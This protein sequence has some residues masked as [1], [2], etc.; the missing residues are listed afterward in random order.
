MKKTYDIYVTYPEELLTAEQKLGETLQAAVENLELSLY[1]ILN[2]E[3]K[4]VYKGRDFNRSDALKFMQDS[5]L[6]LV[7][8]HPQ[9]GQDSEFISELEELCK[10]F[11]LLVK[12]EIENSGR[13]FKVYLE[14]FKDAIDPPCV[15]ALMSYDFFEK[16]IY[17]RRI[18]SLSFDTDDVSAAIYSKLLDLSYD[19]AIML[20][21]SYG[22]L[23]QNEN[24]DKCIFLGITTFDQQSARDEIRRELM[25]YGYKVLPASKI[26][27][28][29]EAFE[30]SV[31]SCLQRSNIVIQLMGAQY[32]EMLKG[33]KH[34]VIDY[35]NKLIREFQENA[36]ESLFRRYI[37]IPQ[38]NK[39]SDQRQA[40]YLKRMRRDDANVNTEIIESPLETFKT[41]LSTKLEETNHAGEAAYENI[42][43]VYLLTEEDQSQEVEELYSTLSLSGLKV[44]VLDYEEQIG[45]YARHLQLL[46]DSDAIIIYQRSDNSF[47]LNSKLRDLIKAPGLGRTKSLKKVLI[48]TQLLPDAQLIRMIKSRVEII[49]TADPDPDL[50][51]QKLISE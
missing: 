30:R 7:F 29:L 46:K 45:I 34:S 9:F 22:S 42:S 47:W 13:V 8:H 17:N 2:R 25:Y 50:V 18:R 28:E 40:L 51:L 38:N 43:R 23:T 27:L 20:D 26:P 44:R 48:A 21:P 49:D 24:R 6:A 4:V 5:S 14:P 10:Y 15:E 3:I 11:N 36:D 16:N 41:I 39:I 37:W 33:T 19:M 32:G 1:K 35:Q 31:N 12:D